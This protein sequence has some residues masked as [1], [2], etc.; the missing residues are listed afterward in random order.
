MEMWQQFR[1]WLKRE[2]ADARDAVNDLEQRMDRGLTERERRLSETPGEA[3]ERIQQE[4]A[5]HESSFDSVRD[6][7][8]ASSAR[9]DARAELSEVATDEDGTESDPDELDR[10]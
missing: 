3:M 1:R 7:I 2:A 6:R 10:P 8:G 4:I 9:A 5:D